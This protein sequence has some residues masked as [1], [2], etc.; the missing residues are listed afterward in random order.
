M[1]TKALLQ[2]WNE[3]VATLTLMALGLLGRNGRSFSSIEHFLVREPWGG[4]FDIQV[5]FNFAT[6]TDSGKIPFPRIKQLPA[7]WCSRL[8]L[9]VDLLHPLAAI[10]RSSAPE[11]MLSLNDIIKRTFVQGKLGASTIVTWL[12]SKGEVL[13]SNF[14]THRTGS[15]LKKP[16]SKLI[17]GP[18]RKTASTNS[19]RSGRLRSISLSLWQCASIL[20]QQ[21]DV[22]FFEVWGE[23]YTFYWGNH[24][25]Q[26]FVDISNS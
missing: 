23:I 25:S 22:S 7:G 13:G 4:L 15:S 3:T 16:K 17:S 5:S 21:A 18:W 9:L 11:I 26:L 2:V 20:S 8:F 14:I 6:K 1:L 19:V 12:N 10:S 24:S